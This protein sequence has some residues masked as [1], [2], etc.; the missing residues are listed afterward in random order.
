MALALVEHSLISA[1]TLVYYVDGAI[2]YVYIRATK[3]PSFSKADLSYTIP[4]TP[5]DLTLRHV[6]IYI[7]PLHLLFTFAISDQHLRDVC[8]ILLVASDDERLASLSMPL[9]FY[10]FDRIPGCQN[11]RSA[12]FQSGWVR[13]DAIDIFHAYYSNNASRSNCYHCSPYK[14]CNKTFIQRTA[15]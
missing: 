8:K 11:S 3:S 15:P 4:C 12:K 14:P 7:Y 13:L 10:I 9:T 2:S 1:Y 5:K 6:L